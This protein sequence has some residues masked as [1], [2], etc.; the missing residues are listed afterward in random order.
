MFARHAPR[1]STTTSRRRPPGARRSRRFA[2]WIVATRPALEPPF[3]RGDAVEQGQPARL[4]REVH[5]PLVLADF[6]T[7]GA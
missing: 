4:E 6:A 5:A 1:G 2:A 7:T 3:C